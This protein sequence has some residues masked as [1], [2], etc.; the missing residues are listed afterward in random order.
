MKKRS[1]I[2]EKYKWDLTKFCKNDEDFYQKLEKLSSR[3]SEFK[4][5]ENKLS[6]EKILF[7]CLEKETEFEK[8]LSFVVFYASRKLSEDNSSRK[9]NEMNEKVSFVLTNYSNVT[10]FVGVEISKF[11]NQ[12]LKN[13]ISD[14]KFCNYKRYFEGVLRSKKHTL[15]KKEELLL[16]KV[17]ECVGENSTVFDKLSDV[18]IKFDDIADS[19]GKKYEF[20]N[21]KYNLYAESSDRELRKNAFAEMNGR[22]GKYIN[23]ISANYISN[24]KEDCVFAK[25]RKFKSA[26]SAAIFSEEASEKVYNLLIKKVRENIDIMYDYFEI[27]RKLLNLDK[28][29]VYDNYAPVVSEI[30]LKFSYEEAIE[31]IKKA[32]SVLGKD[33]VNL[34]DRAKNE[35]GIDVFPNE[36]KDSGAYSSAVYGATPCVL[37]NF[38]GNLESVFTLA[39]ELGHAM[40][41]YFSNENQPIQ[42]CDYVIFVAEVA[43]TTNEMLLLRYFLNNAKNDKEKMYYFDHFLKQAKSTIFRQT[44]FAEFEEFAHNEYEKERPLSAELLCEKYKELNDFYFGPKVEQI[45]QMQYEWARIPHFYSSFYVYKYATGLICAINISNHLLE[46]NSFAKQYKKFLSSGCSKDPISLLKI[47]GCDLTKEKTFDDSF[48]VCRDYIKK[49]EKLI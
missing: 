10:T 13:L 44:M 7:E 45:P 5:Y 14:A 15:S 46:D 36:N 12:K 20:N 43:S 3:I 2:E 22:Y 28:F 21:S 29:A 48:A 27:K 33:Y 37:T 4:K 39:H 19:K 41:S 26:L 32:V 34:I 24:V 16:S 23:T 8:E 30:D 47:A 38:E 49:W 18:D 11:S 35:R 25:I 6:D 1:E 40:H 9:A 17:S 31:I 42:T